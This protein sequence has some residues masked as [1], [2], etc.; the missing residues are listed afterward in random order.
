MSVNVSD[1]ELVVRDN[2]SLMVSPALHPLLGILLLDTTHWSP[3]EFCNRQMSPITGGGKEGDYYRQQ[4]CF[5]RLLSNYFLFYAIS[6]Y[7]DMTI[8]WNVNVRNVG[9]SPS[10]YPYY[11]YRNLVTFCWLGLWDR[12]Y[13]PKKC[14]IVDIHDGWCYFIYFSLFIT[15]TK[16]SFSPLQ[17]PSIVLSWVELLMEM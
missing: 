10:R 8:K 9:W 4:N 7:S 16:F 6:E 13:E 11:H 12:K 3:G 15:R 5:L 17:G 14:R 1:L 2:I